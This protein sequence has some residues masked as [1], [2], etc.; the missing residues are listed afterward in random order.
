M[1]CRM[2]QKGIDIPPDIEYPLSYIKIIRYAVLLRVDFFS[3]SLTRK[4]R[5]DLRGKLGQLLYVNMW[6]DMF[7]KTHHVETVMV[8]EPK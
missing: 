4:K 7:P 6:R 3:D 8:I 5:A 1:S 2:M